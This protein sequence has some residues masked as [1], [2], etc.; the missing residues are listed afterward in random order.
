MPPL[1]MSQAD[2]R[3]MTIIQKETHRN[4]MLI[5]PSYYVRYGII[6]TLPFAVNIFVRCYGK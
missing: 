4:I 3:S 1:P 5:H 2:G 6:Y